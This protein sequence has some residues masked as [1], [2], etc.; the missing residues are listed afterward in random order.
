MLFY[1]YFLL[2][3][4]KYDCGFVVGWLVCG[5]AAV[6]NGQQA[7]QVKVREVAKTASPTTTSDPEFVFR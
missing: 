4:K 6:L 1:F 3:K 5:W 7:S 2:S